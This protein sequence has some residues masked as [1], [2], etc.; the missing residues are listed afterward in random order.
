[1]STEQFEKMKSA[2]G[3]V[4]ALDQSGGSTPKALTR[5]GIDESAY[6][7]ETE[8]F[9]LIHDMRTRI[10]TSPVFGG[11]RILGSIL[12][13]MTME[14]QIMG[15]G[16]AEYLWQDKDIVPFLKVDKGLATEAD[17]A[18]VMKPVPDLDAV[19]ARAIGHGVFGTKMRSVIKLGNAAGVG[20]V[21]SQQ[22]EVARQIMAAGLVP[23]IEPEIDIHSPEKAAAE[24]L[25]K[26]ALMAELEQLDPDQ[27]VMFK[28][29]PPD[30]DNFYAEFVGHPNVLRVVALSGG[31]SREQANAL[32]ARNHGVVASFSR[33][34][35]E[36]LS[37]QQSQ[38]EFDATLDTSIGSIYA[39]SIT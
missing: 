26:S 13:E 11:D 24:V 27:I 18:Q 31:Y 36:G 19:L 34:L 32:L 17:G 9:D 37:A 23:I 1:V 38:A 16:S 30:E 5:Y 3:F 28:L 4:A 14:R 20:A 10:I 2:K 6:S 35:T 33:A 21:V 12:F 7:D 25:L 22:F 15:K 39:A 8:M 29:T